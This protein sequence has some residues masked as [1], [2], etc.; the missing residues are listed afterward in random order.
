M[1]NKQFVPIAG[2][3][4]TSLRERGV[5]KVLAISHGGQTVAIQSFNISKQQLV[6]Q[7]IEDVPSG[8]LLPFEEDAS[9]AAGRIARDVKQ[10]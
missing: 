2:D 5:F 6:D 8:T 1:A 10:K 4:V 7:P 9:Q 3:L